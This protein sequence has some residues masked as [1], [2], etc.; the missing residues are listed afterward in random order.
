MADSLTDMIVFARVVAAGS[1][2]AAARELNLSL[3]VASR[4]LARLEARLGVR[5][6]NRTTRSLA[7]TEEGAMFHARVVR[8]LA[9]ID[10]AELEATRSKSIA[11]GLLRITSTVNF[12]RLH[13]AP[14]LA[15]FQAMH[16]GL[17]IS[18]HA[19][20]TVVDIVEGG[21]DLAIR[22]GALADSSLIAQ[23]IAPDARIICAS[24]A[25]LDRR[26]RPQSVEDLITHDCI[27]FGD[28]PAG[29]WAFADGS[30]ARLS[31]AL[32][33]NTGEVAH[34]WALQSAGLVLKSA[35]FVRD[36]IK[37]GR[38]ETVLP[39]LPLPAS[40]I[41]AVYPHSRHL[42]ARVRLCVDFLAERLEEA[43]QTG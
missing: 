26:G 40:P 41:H 8:I 22:F 31:G 23:R 5:L 15:E 4:R 18:L 16:P 10:E 20:D 43:W 21:F 12:S 37:A 2:S 33:T 3:T 39:H 27:S 29:E 28:P 34:E 38:L 30:S 9:D 25:Y 32:V 42:A 35:W 1:L 19:S 17:R 36:D 14:L 6:L 24:P 11:A 7:L 13:L